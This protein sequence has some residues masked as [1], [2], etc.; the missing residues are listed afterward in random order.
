MRCLLGLVG[1]LSNRGVE[2]IGRADE[3]EESIEAQLYDVMET[4]RQMGP[5][6]NNRT[7]MEQTNTMGEKNS[8]LNRT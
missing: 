3:D 6:R 2:W 7:E 4:V 1:G 8:Y 5:R